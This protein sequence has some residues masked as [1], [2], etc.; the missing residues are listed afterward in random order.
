MSYCYV[1]VELNSW[2]C[3]L[4]QV[5]IGELGDSGKVCSLTE[6]NLVLLIFT[7]NPSQLIVG[8]DKQCWITLLHQGKYLE[9]DTGRVSAR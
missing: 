8:K 6:L 9:F 2:K 5:Y 3:V 1:V 4:Q 7:T